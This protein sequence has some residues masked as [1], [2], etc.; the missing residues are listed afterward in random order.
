M[1]GVHF[2]EYGRTTSNYKK[3]KKTR[4]LV[5]LMAEMKV[6]DSIEVDRVPDTVKYTI[7]SW[8][9]CA[10]RHLKIESKEI[11]FCD[12][13]LEYVLDCIRSM[14]PNPSWYNGDDLK[15]ADIFNKMIVEQRLEYTPNLIRNWA[16]KL[17]D[18]KTKSYFDIIKESRLFG[19]VK[20]NKII[21]FWDW[22]FKVEPSKNKHSI[23]TGKY[24]INSIIKRV[25]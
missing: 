8:E 23:R 14:T 3:N 15:Y 9:Y 20:T 22:K 1:K 10:V 13:A 12:D 2:Y 17:I 11:D 21:P 18:F 19:H 6:D 4:Q 7:R 5:S 16:K 25:K 24:A